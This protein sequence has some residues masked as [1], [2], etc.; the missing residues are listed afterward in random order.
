[1]TSHLS[2]LLYRNANLIEAGISPS[3]VFDG[4][5]SE[6]KTDTI[7]ERGERRAKAAEE[8]EEAKREGDLER[9]FT[10]ATQAS[11]MTKDVVESSRTLLAHLGIPVVQ[12]P[13]EGEAQA[14]YMALKGDVWA[15]SSQDYDSLLFG[16]PRLIRN[17]T[18]TGRRKMPRGG[19]RTVD[20]E[21][22]EL[23]K[24]LELN[25]ITRE[26]L[27]DVCILIGTD[28]NKGI[29][30]I[31]PKRALKLVKELED[32]E[33]IFSKLDIRIEG[34]E[35]IRALFLEYERTDE[36]DL[37]W[38]APDRE[39]VMEFLCEEHD[40]SADRVSST[41]DRIEA[42]WTESRDSKKQRSLDMFF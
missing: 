5:P 34:Y 23:T 4:L 28:Y 29:S 22:V 40:F 32:M 18:I 35:E 30:G 39:R 42:R 13:G 38:K 41:L 27:V 24:V 36:Y 33:A 31:G 7:K 17:L 21:L 16:A 6:R 12:A 3:Y 26:Q 20:L 8:W 11:R 25:D 37:G 9:A 19:Y 1:M 15:S 14:A 10:K 2:G